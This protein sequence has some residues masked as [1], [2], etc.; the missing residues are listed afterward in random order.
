MTMGDQRGRLS[1]IVVGVDGSASS[2]AA[3][4]WAH[5]QATLHDAKLTAVTAWGP[6][7][8][9]VSAGMPR[10]NVAPDDIAR[11]VLD[12]TLSEVLGSDAVSTIDRAI[13]EGSPSK[14]LIDLSRDADLLVV[15]SRGLGG[16]AGLL[17]GSVSQQVAQH[18]KCPVV[19]IRPPHEGDAS[20]S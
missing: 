17:L 11:R 1:R 16:F 8:A 10:T 12:Q 4:G 3:L 14:V 9:T 15:G 20:T 2:R 18:A 13:V 6:A 5:D 19:V 7:P